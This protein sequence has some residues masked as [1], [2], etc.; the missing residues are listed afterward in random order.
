MIPI[1]YSCTLSLY[2][3]VIVLGF[4]LLATIQPE[5]ALPPVN[6]KTLPITSFR[7]SQSKC[8][9]HECHCDIRFNVVRLRSRTFGVRHV[10]TVT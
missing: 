10:I 7:M 1:M 2:Y 6:L 3:V 9:E 5:W 4:R 8:Y